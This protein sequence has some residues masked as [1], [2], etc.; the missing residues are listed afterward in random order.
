MRRGRALELSRHGAAR[1]PLPGANIQHFDSKRV[2]LKFAG[3][4]G[5]DHAAADEGDN[6]VNTPYLGRRKMM[7]GEVEGVV[8]EGEGGRGEGV[9]DVGVGGPEWGE[10]IGR[11]GEMHPEVGAGV[12]G[13]EGVGGGAREGV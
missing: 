12:K 4:T 7:P 6:G 10:R 3:A 11:R 13:S 2:V 5:H 8:G 9:E 1:G